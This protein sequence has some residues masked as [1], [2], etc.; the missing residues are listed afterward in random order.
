MKTCVH[1]LTHSLL[2][3]KDTLKLKGEELKKDRMTMEI[4]AEG[5]AFV[6]LSHFGFENVGEDYSF[7]Y[8]TSWSS[9]RDMKEL[10]AALSTIQQTSSEIITG[11]E[12]SMR[13][14]ILE[15]DVDRYEIYQIPIGSEARDNKFV[16][17]DE[18]MKTYGEISRDNYAMVY[19]APLKEGDS[20]DSLYE[21]FNIDPPSDYAGHALSISDVVIL[22][23]AH[24][25]K[26]YYVDSIGFKEI[27]F[28]E[29]EP[30]VPGW[31]KSL[32]QEMVQLGENKAE[33]KRIADDLPPRSRRDSVLQSLR[34]KQQKVNAE[35]GLDQHGNM[36]DGKRG[37]QAL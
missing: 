4:E 5:C 12:K 16:P 37:E 21:R 20:L 30:Y 32:K 27:P 29:G 3:D 8:M 7:P 28:K 24:E 10:H 23:Q 11:I 17:F 13:E 25:N 34:E 35:F 19:T 18:V 36:I 15:K 6:C 2:H 33:P 26:A 14:Q 1:E 31:D 9:G 22:H